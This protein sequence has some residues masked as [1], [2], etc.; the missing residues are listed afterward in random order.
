LVFDPIPYYQSEHVMALL[1]TILGPLT[2]IIVKVI[3][4]PAARDR[5]SFM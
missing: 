4:D 5:A 3:P 1:A 2:S